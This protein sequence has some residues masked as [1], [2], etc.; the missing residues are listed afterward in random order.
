MTGGPTKSWIESYTTAHLWDALP[1][2]KARSE[3][4]EQAY[5]NQLAKVGAPGGTQW[6][7][8]MQNAA[9]DRAQG[10]LKVAIR[11]CDVKDRAQAAIENAAHE[12]ESL[13]RFAV[14]AI[15][16]DEHAGFMVTEEL[17]VIDPQPCSD[18]K[19]SK[20]RRLQAQTA[21]DY[22]KARA[23]DLWAS[24]QG[25]GKKLTELAA[26]LD[27]HQ[28]P[29][30]NGA[31]PVDANSKPG[32]PQTQRLRDAL[33]AGVGGDPAA[34]KAA[35]AAPTGTPANPSDLLEKSLPKPQTD[36]NAG[37]LIDSV[38]RIDPSAL[39]KRSW[40]EKIPGLP[41][42]PNTPE[43]KAALDGMRNIYKA[44]GVP[45]DQIESRIQQD[46]KN[47][48]QDRYVVHFND[49]D[50]VNKAPPAEGLHRSFGDKLADLATDR[51]QK[52]FY[53][54]AEQMLQEG[55]NLAGQGGPGQPG[56][57]E[58]WKDLGV[59]AAKGVV[60]QLTNP[61]GGAIDQA[62]DFYHDPADF[63]GKKLFEAAT[64]APTLPFGGEGA[65][66][67]D[68]RALAGHGL[69]DVGHVPPSTIDHHVPTSGDHIPVGGDHGNYIPRTAQ[70]ILNDSLT[71]HRAD[72]DQLDWARGEQNL[73]DLA[74]HHGVPVDEL[75]RTPQY[76]IHH[77]TYTDKVSA[78]HAAEIARQTQLW[79]HG[80][81]TQSV[82]QVLE[83]MDATRLPTTALR[84]DLRQGLH[85]Y[86]YED[87][88][89]AGYGPEE[90]GRLARDYADQQFPKD[91][92]LIPQPVLHNPDGAIGGYREPLTYGD[93]Q[94]NN[95]LGN[96]TKQERDALRIWLQNQP[97]DSI[98][99]IRLGDGG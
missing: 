59:G 84:D 21:E 69:E 27:S 92:G 73:H 28:F 29:A 24:D 75:P 10:D 12:G 1:K 56:A 80:F 83:N 44:Q 85:D 8:Q 53:G 97:P 71:A 51:P 7:G 42:N 79:E 5:Q 65:A 96:L 76:D 82:Q 11:H 16:A 60:D 23:N 25:L 13:H 93:W 98:V 70:D 19:E 90:A 37:R 3:Q 35:D 94:V 86:S 33:F 81:N 95:A 66:L 67:T 46:I 78:D 47:A 41:M 91:S 20:E 48:A 14:D 57:V 22:L 39:A 30:E 40:V 34:T 61:L 88:R 26:E 99:N 2:I 87:L 55:K 74:A 89:A 38:A 77:P 31:Q 68:A 52:A 63:T 15:A 54:A 64:I 43:G 50:N 4:V 18:S 58:A 62:K 9:E 17:R 32:D 49:P 36:P 6:T 72:R 45:A